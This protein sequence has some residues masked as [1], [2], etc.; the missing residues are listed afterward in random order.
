MRSALVHTY[1]HG[2]Y[3]DKVVGEMRRK[4]WGRYFGALV[5]GEQSLNVRLVLDG[6]SQ[7][8][9]AALLWHLQE[10]CQ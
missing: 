3:V 6:L 5:D 9:Q 8:Q 10:V 7:R 2:R 4:S 1:I